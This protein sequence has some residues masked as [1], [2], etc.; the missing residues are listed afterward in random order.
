MPTMTVPGLAPDGPTRT[1]VNG[2]A[3][4]LKNIVDVVK[5][6]GGP[7]MVTVPGVAPEGPTVRV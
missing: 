2:V 5:A 1:L 7:A 6:S 4:R 3:P